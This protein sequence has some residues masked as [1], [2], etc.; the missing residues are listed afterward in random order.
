MNCWL[1][2]RD[3]PSL[4]SPL[5]GADDYLQVEALYAVTH[6]GAVIWTTCW[7]GAPGY[8]SRPGTAAWPPTLPSPRSWQP[9]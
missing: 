7:P 4:G 3:E 5:P 1:L 8:R 9:R 2:L 6:E